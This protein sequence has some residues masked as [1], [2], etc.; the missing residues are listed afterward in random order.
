MTS[1]AEKVDAADLAAAGKLPS[2]PFGTAVPMLEDYFP[3][4]DSGNAERFAR[5]HGKDVRHCR[6]PKQ[7]L[8]YDG[9]RF[10]RDDTGEVER[11]A[12]V[13]IR[14]LYRL[15]AD[16]EKKD[17]R[18]AT[19]T[20]ARKSEAAPR[21]DAMLHLARAERAI[22]VRAD[23]L[24][25][26][27][28]LLNAE[29]GTIDLRS[30]RLRQ[31][32]RA[33]LITKLAPVEF[34]PTARCPTWEA[35][36]ERVLPDKGTRDFLQ[37]WTGYALTGDVSAEAL[38][39]AIGKGANGKS[40]FAGT[41]QE[42]LGDYARSVNPELLL[43]SKN[44]GGANR[45]SPDLMALRGVRFALCAETEE[46]RTLSAAMVKRTSST[47]KIAARPLH[48]ESCEFSPSHKLFLMTN[49]RPRVRTADDGTWRRIFY[50]PF[51]VTIPE[52]QQDKGLRDKLR[53]ELPGILAWAVRGCLEWQQ[54]GGGRA[55]LAAPDCVVNATREY[56]E[57]EDVLAPF[58]ADACVLEPGAT[59]KKGDLYAAY[60]R[61]A[62]RNKEAAEGSR[63]FH[64]RI[65]DLPGVREE[66]TGD[67][68]LWRGIR[69]G[70]GQ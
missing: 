9:A 13:T 11:R 10:A 22:A 48:A 34:D 66:R 24:D 38:C 18:E 30:G 53:A 69:L 27:P 4:T 52:A 33:D 14:A 43:A 70:S 3:L 19:A 65:A 26:D 35:F 12:K 41:L 46:G 1:R 15:A 58:L 32:S 59:V 42:L 36:L 16:I 25:A 31:H 44:D 20:W 57:A 2:D 8:V 50:V 67:A 55:G 54:G 49:H 61:W 47:D 28:Y 40:T 5:E 62:E 29:N 68:R 21:R 37:R 39:V 56:R 51:S 45:A 60:Q 7:W 64:G 23:Q 6:A 17:V 63:T